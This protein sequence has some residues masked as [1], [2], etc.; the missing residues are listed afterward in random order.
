MVAGGKQ[1]WGGGV[2]PDTVVWQLVKF[3]AGQEDQTLV[4]REGRYTRLVAFNQRLFIIL[5]CIT[6]VLKNIM[7]KPVQSGR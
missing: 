3:F 4:S 6:I 7:H 5:R 1:A 2:S